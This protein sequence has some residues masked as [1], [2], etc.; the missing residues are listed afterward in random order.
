M[1]THIRSGFWVLIALL[2]CLS[3]SVYSVSAVTGRPKNVQ[4]AL[5]AKW[6]GTPILLEAGYSRSSKKSHIDQ[7]V[8]FPSPQSMAR[9]IR[10]DNET[11]PYLFMHEDELASWIHYQIDDSSFDRESYVN[12]GSFCVDREK[13]EKKNAENSSKELDAVG[14]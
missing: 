2:V 14:V 6:S 7:E 5:R 12:L 9:N 3:L 1:K 8:V 11:T 10:S 4:V 13:G